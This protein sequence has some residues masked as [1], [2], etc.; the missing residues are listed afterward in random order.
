MKTND[1][2]S[3]LAEGNVA[4][5]RVPASSQRKP[6][7]TRI[8]R[9]A[10]YGHYRGFDALCGGRP[11]CLAVGCSK[12]LRKEQPFACSPEHE[13]TVRLQLA[14]LSRAVTRAASDE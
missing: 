12:W 3:Q 7:R 5:I 10:P 14:T 9:V 8:I 13:R 6:T 4:T 2:W 1:V 11:R